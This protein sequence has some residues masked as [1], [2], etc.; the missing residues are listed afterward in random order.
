[1]NDFEHEVQAMRAWFSSPRFVGIQRLYSAR[2]VV[3]QRGT[4][5]SECTVAQD[6]A[7]AFFARLREL[8]EAKKS[9]TT[10][11]PYSPGQAVVMKRMGR[12][13]RPHRCACLTDWF[14]RAL[15]PPLRFAAPAVQ[16]G[17]ARR[18]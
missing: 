16:R 14:G 11:G 10:F 4:I 18:R 17:P 12:P 2:E 6:A 7:E 9:I 15:A 1:M 5:R 8:F 3:E 13:D